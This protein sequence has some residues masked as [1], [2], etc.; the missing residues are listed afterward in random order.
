MNGPLAGIRVLELAG[1]G[2]TPL[3]GMMLADLGANIIRI[4]RPAGL[5]WS[6]PDPAD[7]ILGRGRRSIGLNLKDQRGVELFLRMV[8]NA[9]VLIEGYRPGVA[10]RLGIGPTVC[11]ERQPR[12]VYG[13]MTGWGQQGPLAAAA[14]HDINYLALSGALHAIGSAGGPPVPPLNLVADGSGGMMLAF[15]IAC[16]L[17]AVRAS[18]VGQVIDAAMVDSVAVLMAPFYAHAVSGRWGERGTNLI[19]SG[20]PFYAVY[21]TADGEYVAVGALEP[22]FYR[23]LLKGLELEDIDPDQQMDRAGWPALRAAIAARFASRTRAEWTEIFAD[24]DTCVSP[25]LS[26]AEAVTHPHYVARNGFLEVAGRPHPAPA[27]RFGH[28]PRS[29]PRP[30]PAIGADTDAILAELGLSPD[31]VAATRQDGIAS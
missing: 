27:P 1:Q 2:P 30:A 24:I 10:E 12:L 26:P 31:E 13:R 23:G 16:A 7:D 3:A 29:D 21:P 11:L 14:G 28:H 9:D 18:G 25:V 17:N 15:G 4:D 20:A 8:E 19:D 5:A 22:A 6:V